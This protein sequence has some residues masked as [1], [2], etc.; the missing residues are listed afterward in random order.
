VS[1]STSY[2]LE[3]TLNSWPHGLDSSPLSE[4]VLS[5]FSR[6]GVSD[7]ENPVSNSVRVHKL[8]LGSSML[9]PVHLPLI[10]QPFLS[11]PWTAKLFK[12]NISYIFFFI[13]RT[14]EEFNLRSL[15]PNRK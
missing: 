13:L 12:K 14:N 10:K 7:L 11:V 6:K 15:S 5:P 1:L 9:A 4:C 3:A 2:V 8:A